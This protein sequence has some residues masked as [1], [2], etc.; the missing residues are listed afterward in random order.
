MTTILNLTQHNASPAQVEAGIVE[1][2]DKAVV[3]ALLT[4]DELPTQELLAERARA[5][6]TMVHES[7]HKAVM[8]GGA[9]FFMAPLE[10]ALREADIRPLYAFS[11][12]RSVDVHQPDGSV[13]KQTVFDH[14]GFVG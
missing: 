6:T 1:P 14:L 9:P 12:R 13:R 7:G 10:L 11:V 4:F 8:I 5:L 2:A 3:Q